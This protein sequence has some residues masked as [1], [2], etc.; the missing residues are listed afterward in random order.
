[1]TTEPQPARAAPRAYAR[2]PAAM[3]NLLSRVVVGAVGLPLVLGV[4]WLGHWYLFVLA[5]VAGI[6]ALHE[7]YAMTRPLRPIGIAGHAGLIGLLFAI[8]VST[9]T[10]ALG[11]LLATLGL[12]FLLKGLAGTSGSATVSVST[13][14]LGPAWIGFGL[15]FVL[16]LRDIHGH[17]RLVAYTMLLAVFANDTFAYLAGRALGRHKL[18]PALSPGKTLEGFLVG[19]AACIF[20]AFVA[21]YHDR[22]TYLSI[23]QALLLGVVIA[24]AAPAGDLFVSML[25]RDMGV[26]D[27]GEL[28]G[29]HGGMLDRLDS[30]LFA[31]VAAFYT[32]LAFTT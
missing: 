17:G 15:G 2:R 23:G 8:Q 29:G 27:T 18:A 5:L 24:A 14:L 19:T 11:A 21:L 13:T 4:V 6:V 3:S 16:L 31:S 20:V 30:I 9:L 22:H 12:A 28:L 32:V 7:F 26:K 10:W 25:K 1:M